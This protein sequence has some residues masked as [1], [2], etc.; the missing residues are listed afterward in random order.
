V[1]I[2]AI[3]Y[4]SQG[5]D[6]LYL[7][8]WFGNWS[9]QTS[10]Y[11]KLRELPHPD[12]MAPKDKYYYVPTEAGGYPK[13]VTE[14]GITMTLPAALELNKPTTVHCFRGRSFIS[15][16]PNVTLITLGLLTRND[17]FAIL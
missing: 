14:S 11:E 1:K 15:C 9:Y 17:N 16:P 4:R 10:F 8:H 6:G 13:P 3:N 12:V 5:V 2:V 7:A